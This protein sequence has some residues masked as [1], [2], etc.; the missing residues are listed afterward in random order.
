MIGIVLALV[1]FVILHLVSGKDRVEGRFT[2]VWVLQSAYTLRL[3]LQSFLRDIPFFSHG[4]GGDC[5]TYEFYGQLIA[6]EWEHTGV[7]YVTGSEFDSRVL[8]QTSLPMNVFGMVIYLNGGPTRLGCTAIVALCACLTCYNLYLLALE[9][10]ASQPFAFKV[11]VLT[12]FGP[13]IL[14]YTSDTYKDG[15]VALFT[16]AAVGYAF[17]LAHRFSWRQACF[18]ALCLFG[19]WQVRYYLVFVSVLPLI[20]GITGLKSRTI[21]RPLAV[22]GVLCAIGAATVGYSQVLETAAE[23]AEDAFTMGTSEVVVQDNATG[24]SGVTFND[25]GRAFGAFGPKV[26][27]MLFSPFP[28]QSGSIGFQIGKLDALIWY[29]LAYRAFV[30]ARRLLRENI[31]LLLMFLIFLLPVVVAYSASM[32]NIGLIVRQRIPLVLICALLAT[33]SEPAPRTQ[34]GPEEA[35]GS[36]REASFAAGSTAAVH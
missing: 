36:D 15:F 9:L 26:A 6:T 33:L 11:M 13:A 12:L 21:W 16:T 29:Y 2:V 1:G 4:A 19:L 28:W 7:H 3:I 5:M 25:G 23:K 27:Y 17:R 24:G 10:G 34:E 32:S 31:A 20:V 35:P 22:C 8:T 14:M 18:A 30:G